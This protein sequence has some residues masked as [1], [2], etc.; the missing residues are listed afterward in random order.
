MIETPF[1][2]DPWILAAT[3]VLVLLVVLLI[4]GAYKRRR[5]RLRRLGASVV[6]DR[7][8]PPA[9]ERSPWRRATL[10]GVAAA[11]AG[12]ALACPRWGTERTV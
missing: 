3:P 9:L 12:V 11:F 7:L 2:D 1:F 8:L 10:I 6:I 5:T 4:V